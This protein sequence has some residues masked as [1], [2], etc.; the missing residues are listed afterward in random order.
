MKTMCLFTLILSSGILLSQE[1]HNLSGYVRDSANGEELI[2]ATVST[3]DFEVIVST[4]VYG[5]YSISLTAGTYEIAYSFIGYNELKKT[6]TVSE[7]FTLDI[8][9]TSSSVNISE[10]LV[11]GESENKNVKD[12]DMSVSEMDIATITSI[13][14]L[15]GE[16]D[17]IRA[18]QTM[19]GV[20]TVGEGASGFNVRG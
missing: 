16:A 19:P 18:V 1:K 12:I 17:V 8:E 3:A 2:G 15:L 13:P 10:A 9:L 4:N 14:A 5:F 20:T 7:N 11:T 6:I